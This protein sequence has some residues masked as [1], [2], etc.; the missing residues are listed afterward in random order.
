[1]N[2]A[3]RGKETFR[4]R[5]GRVQCLPGETERVLVAVDELEVKLVV[6]VEVM[7][8]VK[9]YPMRDLVHYD[10]TGFLLP[11]IHALDSHYLPDAFDG[12]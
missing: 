8:Q 7:S 3:S 6:D 5:H 2:E 1:M 10:L 4:P 12:I 11:F 9:R